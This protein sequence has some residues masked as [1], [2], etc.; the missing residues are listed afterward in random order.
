MMWQAIAEHIKPVLL[1][2][3]MD[4]ALLEEEL[5]PEETTRERQCHRL[6]LWRGQ[7]WDHW[8]HHG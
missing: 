2:N 3:K 6:H 4:C 5:E 7:E 8:Q 1:M